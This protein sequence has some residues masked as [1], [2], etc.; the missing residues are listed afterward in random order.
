MALKTP[1]IER[2]KKGRK[3]DE[4]VK[5]LDHPRASVRYNAFIALAGNTDPGEDVKKRLARM[6]YNDP[7]TWVRTLATLRFAKLGDPDV[8]DN[9]F[10][11][12]Q[13][14]TQKSRLDLLKIITD[15]GESSDVTVLQ[16]IIMGLADKNVLVRL[17]AIT[18]ANAAKN[19][20]LMPYLGA[21]LNEQHSKLRLMAAKTLYNIG[22]NDS[23]EY[24]IKLLDDKNT[25]VLSAIRRYITNIISSPAFK[26]ANH[27]PFPGSDEDNLSVEG[28]S[29]NKPG[30]SGKECIMEAL[31]ILDNACTH[32]FRGVRI[33]ALKSIAVFRHPHSIDIVERLMRDKFPEVRLE[34]LHTLEK[35]GGKRALEIVAGMP[36]DKKRLIR[37]ETE[38]ALARMKK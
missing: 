11:I 4:L 6:M 34:A 15:N 17:Q 21:M 10:H 29:E 3:T 28:E 16:L 7:D 24:L 2:L 12:M 38:R 37:D 35:I 22:R 26:A 25:E 19:E 18:S 32:K 20:Q 23:L 14:G 31:L 13:E 30:K 27:D 8:S 36:R 9:F 33:E 1:D 5:C